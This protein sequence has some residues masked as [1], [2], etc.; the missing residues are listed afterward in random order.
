MN[1]RIFKEFSFLSGIHAENK[2]SINSYEIGLDIDV[3]TED[4]KEQNI[5]MERIK[6]LF[7]R[8]EDCVF[9]N[10]QEKN[11]IESYNKAG[12]KVCTLPE[13]PYDQIVAVVLIR[14]LNAITEGKLIVEDIS[15]QSLICDD[16]R[17]FVGINETTN[18]S[19]NKSWFNE[20][21]IAI[22]NIPKYN[23]KEKI[24]SLRKD[25]LDW[26]T[27]GLV[28]KEIQESTTSILIELPNTE[29]TK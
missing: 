27:L 9:I 21:N 20:N 18:F 13:D 23:K 3:N 10:E 12:L 6:Y 16:I 8:I 25:Y 14:K 5:A 29:F 7:S 19:N 11:C 17:F 22:S 2:F 15:I 4:I 24:V 28:W 1:A 26:N